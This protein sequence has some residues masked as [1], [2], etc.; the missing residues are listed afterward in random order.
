MSSTDKI[1]GKDVV[2][3]E[4]DLYLNSPI[5]YEYAEKIEKGEVGRLKSFLISIFAGADDEPGGMGDAIRNATQEEVIDTFLNNGF[6]F[7]TEWFGKRE[8]PK[9]VDGRP[10]SRLDDPDYQRKMGWH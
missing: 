8:L 3:Y 5:G 7:D 2:A 1:L 9:G 4:G 6:S 10:K